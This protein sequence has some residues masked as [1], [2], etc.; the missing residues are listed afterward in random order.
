[1]TE[2]IIFLQ[3]WVIW[4]QLI[5]IKILIEDQWF[6]DP[7]IARL[8]VLSRMICKTY[9]PE[10]TGANWKQSITLFSSARIGVKLN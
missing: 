2:I 9:L 10:V 8:C 3:I 7:A 6:P 5:T 4:V 1:M